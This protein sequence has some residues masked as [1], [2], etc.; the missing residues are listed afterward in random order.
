MFCSLDLFLRYWRLRLPQVTSIHGLA[1]LCFDVSSGYYGF[2]PLDDSAYR[3]WRR[4]L[5]SDEPAACD[6]CGRNDGLEERIAPERSL[7]CRSCGSLGRWRA[8]AY[9][10]DAIIRPE[11]SILEVSHTPGVH[12]RLKSRVRRLTT[13]DIE[14]G[15][16]VGTVADCSR[17]PFADGSFD[18]V[19]HSHVLEHVADDVAVL[20]ECLRVLRPGGRVVFNVP[21]E[22]RMTEGIVDPVEIGAKPY[23]GNGSPGMKVR[24]CYSFQGL[25]RR[26]EDAGLSAR[27][28]VHTGINYRNSRLAGAQFSDVVW[29]IRAGP[30]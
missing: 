18:L 7:Y 8:L 13:V 6:L 14:P 25:R 29:E 15:P 28:V 21:F 11:M 24:R 12:E 2:E 27:A 10:L 5:L 23:H 26:L 20:R 3:G 16:S 17:L 4:A 9:Y 30:S 1:R 19:V 22:N